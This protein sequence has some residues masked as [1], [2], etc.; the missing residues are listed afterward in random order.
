MLSEADC[1]KGH[2]GLD[3]ALAPLREMIA[4]VKDQEEG[5]K[6]GSDLVMED[7]DRTDSNGLPKSID[8]GSEAASTAVEPFSVFVPRSIGL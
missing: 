8:G 6:S 4:E 1:C 2:K 3:E 5:Q 7:I